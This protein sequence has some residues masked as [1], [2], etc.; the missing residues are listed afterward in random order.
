[1]NFSA[2]IKNVSTHHPRH[3]RKQRSAFPFHSLHFPNTSSNIHPGIGFAILQALATRSP[4]DHYLL[5]SRDATK[6]TTAISQLRDLGITSQIDVLTLDVT[7][8]DSIRAAEKEIREKYK[9]LD[10]P[11][12]PLIPF[13]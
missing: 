11:S 5:G 2:S 10:S 1:L 3:R 7:S 13:V 12:S 6:G 9:K 4:S 8:D